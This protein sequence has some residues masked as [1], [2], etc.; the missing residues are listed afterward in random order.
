MRYLKGVVTLQ[1]DSEK[2]IGCRQCHAVCPHR[3]FEMRNQKAVVVDL[4]ACMECGAC[5][6]NCPAGALSVDPGV[7]CAEYIISVW[8]KGKENASCGCG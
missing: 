8:L 4:D 3:V 2:C 1:L 5:A 7:G 6:L